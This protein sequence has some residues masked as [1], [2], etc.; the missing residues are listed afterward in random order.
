MFAAFV[1]PPESVSDPGERAALGI[2]V[3]GTKILATLAGSDATVLKEVTVASPGDANGLAFC[4]SELTTKVV[5]DLSSPIVALGIALPG[6]VSANGRL[7]GA[8]HLSVGDEVYDAM[9]E[10]G[11]P[12]CDRLGLSKD[13]VVFDNDATAAAYGEFSCGAAEGV[14]D[15]VVLTLGTGIGGG[16]IMNGAIA[17]GQRRYA[18]EFGHV[19]VDPNGPSCPC[20]RKGCLETFAS[21]SGIVRRAKEA[22]ARGVKSDMLGSLE[23]VRGEDVF[24]AARAG[25]ALGVSLLDDLASYLALGIVNLIEM[26]D[27]ARIVLGGGMMQEADL[28]FEA[29][30]RYYARFTRPV[31]QRRVSVVVPAQLGERATAIGIAMLA[32]SEVR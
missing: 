24:A 8:P 19:V 5:S 13:R 20:G 22:L 17:R 31:Q 6:L 32:L 4:L 14:L 28:F 23:E 11:S 30:K 25:D 26:F 10:L 7:S 29:T 3:G 27:P 18:G 9:S 12:L 2:D 16:I 15:A 1:R 21:G